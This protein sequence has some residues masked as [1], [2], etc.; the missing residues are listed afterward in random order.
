MCD[1]QP[2]IPVSGD[3]R[4]LSAEEEEAW[5]RQGERLARDHGLIEPEAPE[6]GDD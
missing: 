1:Q 5:R 3:N 2:A 6:A 4:P